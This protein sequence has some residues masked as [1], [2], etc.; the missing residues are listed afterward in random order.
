MVI[1]CPNF[2]IVASQGIG[3]SEERERD[4]EQLVS[5]AVRTHITFID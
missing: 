4:G 2:N 5:G 3:R 1:N